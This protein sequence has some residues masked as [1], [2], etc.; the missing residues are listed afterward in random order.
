MI[1]ASGSRIA[2]TEA[3]IKLLGTDMKWITHV[4]ATISEVEELLDADLDYVL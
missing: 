4:P 2:P 1:K 3:N